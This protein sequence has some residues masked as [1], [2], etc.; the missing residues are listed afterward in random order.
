MVGEVEAPNDTCDH[1]TIDAT[2]RAVPART[3]VFPMRL[4]S[5]EL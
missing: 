5:F 4:H 3:T 2:I 1:L